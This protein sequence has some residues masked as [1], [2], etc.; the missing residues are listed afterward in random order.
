MSKE[1]YAEAWRERRRGRS[2]R[3][4]VIKVPPTARCD[5]EKFFL[6]MTSQR[7]RSES[8]DLLIG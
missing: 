1:A 3:S 6:Q 2:G 4:E 5:L 8:L 7:S